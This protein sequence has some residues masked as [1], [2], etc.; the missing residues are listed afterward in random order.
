MEDKN[1]SWTDYFKKY[2][3][4]KGVVLDPLNKALKSEGC[5]GMDL[6]HAN[7]KARFLS[8]AVSYLQ[9][10]SSIY[11]D[12][13]FSLLSKG[14]IMIKHKRLL[15]VLIFKQS[16]IDHLLQFSDIHH[17]KES[18]SVC[19]AYA[20]ATMIRASMTSVIKK[21][22]I[23]NGLELL[24]N[25]NYHKMMRRELCMNICPFGDD[26]T[27]PRMVMILVCFIVFGEKN[28]IFC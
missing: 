19:W 21:F 1:L 7:K 10:L 4:T 25:E 17:Q 24:K 28:K 15:S 16:N 6:S 8:K 12:P 27:D 5:E 3:R 9:K 18:E 23:E 22:N 26:G 20:I 14:L 2:L 11:R 13:K